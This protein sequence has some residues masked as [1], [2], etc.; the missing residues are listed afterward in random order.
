MLQVYRVLDSQKKMNKKTKVR[1]RKQVVAT[2]ESSITDSGSNGQVVDSQE[3]L[4]QEREMER[5][6][7]ESIVLWRSPV[8]TLKYFVL[9]AS[10]LL[11]LLGKRLY[12]RKKTV[13]LCVVFSMVLLAIY[14]IEGAHQQTVGSVEKTVL[15]CAYW[16]G[17]GIL[18]SVGL[19]TGLHTF[20]L[21]LGPHIAAVTLA[22]YECMSTNFPEPPYPTEIICPEEEGKQYRISMWTIISKVRLEAFMWGAGTAIGELPPYF[23]AR[24]ARLSGAD[25]D[26]DEFEE[27]EELLHEKNENPGDMSFLEKAK[28]SVH[29]LVQRVGFFGILL[30]ASIPNPLF[31]LAGITCGHFLI[32][33]WTFFGATL[34]G[35]AIIKMHIQKLFV[36]FLFSE[37]HVETVVNLIGKLPKYGKVLQTPFK[38]YLRLQKQKLHH[39]PGTATSGESGNL[40]AWIFEKVVIVMVAY[41]L[42]SI[43]NSMAQN[44]HKRQCKTKRLLQ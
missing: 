44:Y 13:L 39:K 40:L 36:I 43:I 1:Q 33:F 11:Y 6:E 18:S 10:V 41:F 9:E 12:N 7:R 19:G 5:K 29:N 26:A 27:I 24:A 42:L 35:K 34:I 16:V 37:H 17:L 4:K 25:L 23:M 3:T 2:A 14:N 20:L 8:R 21:Y 30:C 31:D 15:W 38:E 22:A 32:P 28:L